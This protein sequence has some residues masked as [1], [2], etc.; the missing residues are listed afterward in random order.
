MRK[1]KH[2]GK[3][4]TTELIITMVVGIIIGITITLLLS[5]PTDYEVVIYSF[6]G[7]DELMVVKK[8]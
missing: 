3:W 5:T 1:W 4:S 8:H 6:L 2:Y 7:Y